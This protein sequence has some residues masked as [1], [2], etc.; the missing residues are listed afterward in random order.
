MSF[1]RKSMTKD[2]LFFKETKVEYID[3]K[4]WKFQLKKQER[5]YQVT[6]SDQKKSEMK[7]GLSILIRKWFSNKLND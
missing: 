4:S 3:S 5:K 7:I 2:Y 1:K 6:S